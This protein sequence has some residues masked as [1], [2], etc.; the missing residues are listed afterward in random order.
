MQS[1]SVQFPVKSY[2]KKFLVYKFGDNHTYSQHSVLAPIIRSVLS[3]ETT[4]YSPKFQTQH[5]YTINLSD[6]Y[7]SFYGVFINKKNINEFNNDIDALF[8]SEL[9]HFMVFNKEYYN[10]KYRDTLRKMLESMVITETD[11][12]LETILKDFTRKKDKTNAL[13]LG[14][15]L[16][17]KNISRKTA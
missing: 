2:I 3:K 4:Q 16:K 9:F 5:Y 11:V 17:N 8:R 15:F 1:V 6:F 13:N 7:I 12:K 10:I 14:T